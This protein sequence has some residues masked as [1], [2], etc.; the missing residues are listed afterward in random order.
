[1]EAT[2]L[3]GVG[4]RAGKCPPRLQLSQLTQAGEEEPSG[5]AQA[6]LIAGKAWPRLGLAL[7]ALRGRHQLHAGPQASRVSSKRSPRK[8]PT[9]PRRRRVK[10]Q[11]N[12]RCELRRAGGG[13]YLPPGESSEGDAVAGTRGH[14]ILPLTEPALGTALL[15]AGAAPLQG[16]SLAQLPADRRAVPGAEFHGSRRDILGGAGPPRRS[17][18]ASWVGGASRKVGGASG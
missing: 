9:R 18:E 4:Q 13:P 14:R 3:Q 2:H 8:V 5:T 12:S 1:M 17:G 15:G 6:R 7:A 11:P 16:R 10:K